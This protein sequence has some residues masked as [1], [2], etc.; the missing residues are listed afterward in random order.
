[1]TRR[2]ACNCGQFVVTCEGEPPRISVC[3]CLECQRRT[4]SVFS[5]QA[6]FKREQITDISGTFSEYKRLSDDGRSLTFRFCPIC[7]STVCWE[8]ELFPDLMAIG[9]GSFADPAFPGPKNS[10]WEKRRHHWV[11]LPSDPGIRHFD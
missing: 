8:A 2:A 1:M 9:V 4:A 6:W 5:S 3:H 10:V 7:G 11:T